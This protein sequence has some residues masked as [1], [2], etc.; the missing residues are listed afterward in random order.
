MDDKGQ[1]NQQ[2][3]NE[4]ARLRQTHAWEKAAERIRLEVLFM[5]AQDDL[6]KVAVMMFREL[7]SLGMESP[8]C[9]F[10][11]VDKAE[12]RI[13]AYV[14]LKN[15]GK[16]GISWTSPDMWDFDEDTTV[17]VW[18]TPIASDWDEDLGYWR[19]GEPWSLARS[20][21]EDEAEVQPFHRQYG[22]SDHLPYMGPEWPVTNIPFQ[23]GWVSV[24]HP[25]AQLDYARRIGALTEAL[26]LG[27]MRFLDFKQLEENLQ[28]L[29]E[30]QNRLVVQEKMA[31]LGDLV[32]G[33][34]H[35]L[36]NPVGALHSA[37]DVSQ[38]CLERIVGGLSSSEGRQLLKDN[39]PLQ[40]ALQLLQTNHKLAATGSQRI[41]AIVDSLRSFARLDEAEFQMVDIHPGIDSAL[42]LLQ[43]QLGNRIAVVKDYGDIA[44]I[45][46][47]PGQLNQ[48]FMHVL[49]NAVEA[50]DANGEIR[51]STAYADGQVEVR[52]SDTGKGMPP[53]Q[54][55]RIFDVDFRTGDSRVKMGLGLST[56]YRII[57]DHQGEIKMESQVGRGTTVIICL[58]I[59][60]KIKEGHHA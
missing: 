10:F 32:A 20:W 41:T 19:A 48:V 35:E 50:I 36:N 23:H 13:V 54:L 28:L 4:L 7:G 47:A 8:I 1:S 30:T 39:Q 33:V 59:K 16:L 21:E 14:A 52:I 9:V 5:R 25:A 17:T 12:N 37:L 11:F 34:A 60:E 49:K 56:D 26:S 51:I 40:K 43:G 58:P 2:L 45:Y 44:P 24:R 3:Q 46:C 29:K 15:L 6:L 42:T 57:Q 53:E 38:R 55:E 31:A 22:L 27:Y 18:E